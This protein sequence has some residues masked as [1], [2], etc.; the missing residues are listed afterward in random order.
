MDQNEIIWYILIG[1]GVY[2]LIFAWVISLATSNTKKNKLLE[3]Q[4]DLLIKIAQKQG[5]T[6]DEVDGIRNYIER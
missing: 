5:V 1:A 6:Q 3:A 2:F 4:V